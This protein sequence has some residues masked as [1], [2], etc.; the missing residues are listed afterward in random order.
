MVRIRQA[1]PQA[2]AE[3]NLASQIE[4]GGLLPIVSA[5]AL[6]DLVLDGR[7]A[8]VE[9]YA[10]TIDFP[11]PDR[12]RLHTLAKY[13]S[14]A[15]KLK[16]TALK[17]E[18]LDAVA[19][20]L[21]EVATKRGV[22]LQEVEEVK[23]QAGGLKVSDFARRL[24]FPRFGQGAANPLEVLA[25]LPL[26]VYLTTSPYSFIEAALT[27]AGKQPRSDLCRWH[28]G[29]DG[30]PSVLAPGAGGGYNPSDKE[31][32]VYHLFGMDS[33]ED[34]LVLTEDD[35]LDF[36]MA[37]SQG[38]GKDFDPIHPQ[39]KSALHS[40]ALLLLGFSLPTWPFRVLYR[41]LIKPMPGDVYQRYCC[42][43]VLPIKEEQGYYE[44]YLR[45]EAR[46]DKVYWMDIE[47]FFRDELQV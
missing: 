18:F 9:H 25:N 11:L 17:E 32:L 47:R 21:V 33:Y 6:D 30:I 36:L 5:E 44:R 28:P 23:A 10:A 27:N 15:K 3:P 40:K 8:L 1:A 12:T 41:G 45:Q 16:D 43:Q 35:Y 4:R 34:S 24:G 14:L 46:V 19:T 39:V 22:P 31:P 37:V 38:Q 7:A 42:L 29:L 13:R 26:P 20:H 2:K